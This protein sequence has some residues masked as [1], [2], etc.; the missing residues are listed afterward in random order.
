MAAPESD[1]HVPS[2]VQLKLRW[3]VAGGL[4]TIALL[5]GAYSAIR[6]VPADYPTIQSALDAIIDH[7]T[8]IVDTGTY[9]EALDAPPL[10]FVLLGNVLPDTGS[11]PRPVI[12][13][14]DLP[15]SD[16]LM[17]LELTGGD[18]VIVQDFVFRNRA[19]MARP[20]YA[21]G[22]I[23]NQAAQFTARYCAWDSVYY[24]LHSIGHP[25]VLQNCT[26]SECNRFLVHTG[27][28]AIYATDV[29][30][31]GHSAWS[32]LQCGSHST[33]IRC[34]ISNSPGDAHLM[35]VVGTDVS[36]TD[37]IIGPSNGGLNS[38][39]LASIRNSRIENNLFTENE[40]GLALVAM[41]VTC[42]SPV[43]FRNNILVNNF[44]NPDYPAN[45]PR[46][47]SVASDT[48]SQCHTLEAEGN[49]FVSSSCK[50]IST[51]GEDVVRGNRFLDLTGLGPTVLV[52]WRTV[53]MHDNT[54]DRT[55]LAAFADYE[56][57]INAEWNWWGD[58]T[59]PYHAVDN[60][61]GLGDT[62]AGNVD[63]D[64]WYTDTLFLYAPEPR[65]PLPQEVQLEIYPNPFNATATLRLVVNQPGI[66]E[67]DLY[68]TLG[69]H[70]K[71]LWSGA[72][73]DEK[74]VTVD[75]SVLASGLYFV[76][77]W[78]P[79]EN[80]PAGLAKVVLMK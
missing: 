18:S 36:I 59:G 26:F 74:S 73:A 17:C 3:L 8:V 70:V 60:P 52:T 15:G 32:L 44:G 40:V 4:L 45:R 80:R 71:R 57:W 79:L 39:I 33:F 63:F 61:G 49:V 67:V 20:G 7:D 23:R 75:G 56:A 47:V 9:V 35:I 72:V 25:V 6:R 43:V 65:V 14:S 34:S 51:N 16:S 77:V 66:F 78:Q 41:S 24:A 62:V 19:A 76:R 58:R 37:C 54:F 30:F 42:D 46:M 38:P 48:L 5:N 31:R 69:R 13:P 28:S 21:V 1:G 53:R 68:N 10:S 12:D 55:G 50:A 27:S 64:P 2:T 11:Y 29:V 22:G